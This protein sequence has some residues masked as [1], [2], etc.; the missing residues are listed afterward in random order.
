MLF[1]DKKKKKE[2]SQKR[3]E[4]EIDNHDQIKAVFSNALPSV[5]LFQWIIA[6]TDHIILASGN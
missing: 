6:K 2:K 1:N 3:L 5:G 4:S